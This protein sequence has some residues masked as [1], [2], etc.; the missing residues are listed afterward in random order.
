M[1]SGGV[2]T[3]AVD[4][5]PGGTDVAVAIEPGGVDVACVVVGGGIA[6]RIGV[7]TGGGVEVG[8]TSCPCPARL[9]VMLPSPRKPMVAVSPLYV[10]VSNPAAFR[11]SMAVWTA[12]PWLRKLNRP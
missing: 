3:P 8:E 1:L 2:G 7:P 6:V 11:E 9:S 5:P 4:V 12:M 10:L